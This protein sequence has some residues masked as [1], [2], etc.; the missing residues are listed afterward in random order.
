[1]LADAEKDA[2]RFDPP[3]VDR[4]YRNYVETCRRLGAESVPRNHALEW[5]L[6]RVRSQAA[7]WFRRQ[8]FSA[9]HRDCCVN[10]DGIFLGRLQ[11]VIESASAIQL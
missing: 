9:A 2:Q 11:F 6:G 4:V 3:D 1:M 5:R 7:G 8:R 10:A